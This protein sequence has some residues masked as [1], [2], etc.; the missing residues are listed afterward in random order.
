MNPIPTDPESLRRR[1]QL[2]LA[3]SIISKLEF[4]HQK[5]RPAL[6]TMYSDAY[7]HPT[8]QW[9]PGGQQAQA[10]AV[11]FRKRLPRYLRNSESILLKIFRRSLEVC[12]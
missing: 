9:Q 7:N 2:E 1:A 4:R 3:D 8:Q 6:R 5:G 11:R 10:R 12:F